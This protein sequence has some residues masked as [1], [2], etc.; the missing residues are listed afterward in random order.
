MKLNRR[1]SLI[2]VYSW[3]DRYGI[4]FEKK[5]TIEADRIE[6]G[7]VIENLDI[8]KNQIII[9]ALKKANP[10]FQAIF[11][12]LVPGSRARIF[13]TKDKNGLVKGL[14]LVIFIG[15]SKKKSLV[16]LS[17]GQKSL[18]ALSFIFAILT[19]RPA[20]FYI[21]DEIDAALDSCNTENIGNIIKNFFELSQFIIIS[22]KGGLVKNANVIFK[23][24][25]SKEG[26]LVSKLIKKLE[27]KILV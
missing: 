11:N 23:I 7:K 12:G 1:K 26:S 27:K 16:E 18:L 2:N 19:C 8:K 10:S 14:D 22:L 15:N 3:L 17:G 6:I 5:K 4:L 25:S 9:N 24:K 21:L 13:S 20:P